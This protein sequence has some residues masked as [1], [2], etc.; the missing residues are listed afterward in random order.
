MLSEELCD[1]DGL[2]GQ[3]SRALLSGISVLRKTLQGDAQAPLPGRGYSGCA[4][5]PVTQRAP[6]P[7]H[8]GTLILDFPASGSLRKKFLLFLAT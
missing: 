8:A 3:E 2:I 1:W 4:K 7:S 6:S 5:K